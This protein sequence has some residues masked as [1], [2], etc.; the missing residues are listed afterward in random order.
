LIAAL[1]DTNN[2][3]TVSVGDTIQW[4]TYP[5]LPD[6]SNSGTGGT[7]TSLINT[8]TNVV[9]ADSTNILVDTNAGSVHWSADPNLERFTTTAGS[10]GGGAFESHLVDSITLPLVLDT[11]L[12]DPTVFGAGRPNFPVSGPETQTLQLGDQGFLDVYIGHWH[13]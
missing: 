4:G 10:G 5:A 13:L 7:Y 9:A 11:I 1:V 2:D 12:V 6:G 3:N 8:I